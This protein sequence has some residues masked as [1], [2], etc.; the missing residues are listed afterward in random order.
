MGCRCCCRPAPTPR[1]EVLPGRLP[2]ASYISAATAAAS[3]LARIMEQGSRAQLDDAVVIPAQ[4]RPDGIDAANRRVPFCMRVSAWYFR[5]A[6][7]SVTFAPGASYRRKTCP[8]AA[9]D[10]SARVEADGRTGV[11]L[12][13]LRQCRGV[14]QRP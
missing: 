7:T 2:S 1:R 14:R 10:L 8:L 11:Q 12:V 3:T 5:I 13:D 9:G 4:V 6:A